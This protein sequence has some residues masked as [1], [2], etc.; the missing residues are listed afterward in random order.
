MVVEGDKVRVLATGQVGIVRYV[1]T[2]GFILV[3]FAE[4]PIKG[5]IFNNDCTYRVNELIEEA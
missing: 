1:Y 4:R 3:E 2:N 5:G